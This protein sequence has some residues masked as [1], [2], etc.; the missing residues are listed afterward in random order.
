MVKYASVSENILFCA[1]DLFYKQGYH[2]T[3]IRQIQ[4]ASNNKSINY[5]YKNK[6][7]LAYTIFENY[8]NAINDKIIAR[9]I[10]Y[11]NDLFPIFAISSIF[12]K[13]VMEDINSR[14]YYLE[15][16]KDCNDG[17]ADI[18]IKF[19]Y[20][21]I[22]AS[23]KKYGTKQ[24]TPDIIKFYIMVPVAFQE[25][26]FTN[27]YKGDIHLNLDQAIELLLKVTYQLLAIPDEIIEEAFK[28]AI[29]TR[30]EIDFS[31][32]KLL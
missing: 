26:L 5:Y 29:K 22:S 6:K 4:T 23:V 3:T 13:F 12:Y 19:C 31:N 30:D 24:V 7:D 27:L 11:D 21:K 15:T 10:T 32:I 9:N 18:L 20:D 25:T 17:Y 28:F 8:L 16:L 2:D 14:R 1:K